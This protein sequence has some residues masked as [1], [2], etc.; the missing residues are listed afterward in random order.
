[1]PH[2]ILKVIL[3]P[4]LLLQGLW[5]RFKTPVLPEAEG[6]RAGRAGAGPALR[7]LVV[8]DSSAAGVGAATQSQSLLGHLTQGLA[9]RFDVRFRLMAQTGAT[10]REALKAL[11]AMASERWDVVVTALGVNDLTGQRHKTDWLADQQRLID[12]LRSKFDPC[13]ILISSLPPVHRFPALPQPLRW[14]LGKGAQRFNIALEN[15]SSANAALFLPLDFDMRA[16]Q[17][18]PD[19]FH[20]GPDIYAEWGRRAAA[21]I[22]ADLETNVAAAGRCLWRGMPPN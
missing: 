21:R 1:M 7:L 8:G 13:V 12:L 9:R 19:G 15:L 2:F 14:H 20:P 10:T 4:I 22:C 17:M 6:P 5:V 3:G 16:D 11:D 18:A